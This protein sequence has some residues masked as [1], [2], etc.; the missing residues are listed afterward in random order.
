MLHV[1]DRGQLELD[2]DALAQLGEG[3]RRGQSGASARAARGGSGTAPCSSARGPAARAQRGGKGGA[4]GGCDEVREDT[5]LRCCSG[6]SEF[7]V[8]GAAA[9]AAIVL[10]ECTKSAF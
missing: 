3:G 5:D 7:C 10:H 6:P 1:V 8:P 4:E 9:R 2:N